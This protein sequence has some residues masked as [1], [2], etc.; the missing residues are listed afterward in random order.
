MNNVMLAR[1][2]AEGQVTWKKSLRE[3]EKKELRKEININW[4]SCCID[5]QRIILPSACIFR[6]SSVFTFK[7]LLH[8]RNQII[9]HVCSDTF[10]F[11][12]TV[13]WKNSSASFSNKFEEM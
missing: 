1:S 4:Q 13:S 11:L 8:L 9:W 5:S 2:L 6:Y 7:T 12:K 10:L 3:E